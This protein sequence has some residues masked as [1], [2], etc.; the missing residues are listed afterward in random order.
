MAA[1]VARLRGGWR[2]KTATTWH[3]GAAALECSG[4]EAIGRQDS[5]DGVVASTLGGVVA[6]RDSS[7]RQRREERRLTSGLVVLFKI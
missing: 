1:S 7:T 5:K 2:A 6:G 4:G 3:D